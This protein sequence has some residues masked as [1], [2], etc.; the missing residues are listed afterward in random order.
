[1]DWIYLI[2][3]GILEVV[4]AFSM[5]KSE[6]FTQ[7]FPSIIT[8]VFM[9]ASFWL[10]A[11]AM[12]SLPLG[13]SYVIWTGIGAIGSFIVGI[14]FLGESTDFWRLLSITFILLGLVGLKFFS[15]AS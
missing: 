12:R 5:K 9:I 7:L 2:V 13:T 8:L 15:A 6:G 14:I 4:W 11:L 3:A 10:L 1:M